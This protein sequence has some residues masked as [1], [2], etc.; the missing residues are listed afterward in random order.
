MRKL[1]LEVAGIGAAR[2]AE[3]AKF[4]QTS[5]STLYI[6]NPKKTVSLTLISYFRVT[7]GGSL[8]Q[9]SDVLMPA[10]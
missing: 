6:K 1:E 5:K 7:D 4:K 9:V 3:T 10:E 2:L 8:R